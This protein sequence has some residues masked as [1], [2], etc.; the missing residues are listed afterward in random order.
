MRDIQAA[1]ET[2]YNDAGA[3]HKRASENIIAI[4]A[5]RKGAALK[6]LRHD[7]NNRFQRWLNDPLAQFL[8]TWER[9]DRT[10]A[11]HRQLR[12]LGR[13]RLPM[14]APTPEERTALRSAKTQQARAGAIRR[15]I[16]KVRGD[17]DRLAPNIALSV[18]EQRS[19]Q[20]S[21]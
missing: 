19:L 2:L 14:R 9:M 7:P 8:H 5:R 13:A 20:D 3:K 1:L 15:R 17:L 11:R 10:D 18:A 4:Q 16:A 12:R 6:L 21:A